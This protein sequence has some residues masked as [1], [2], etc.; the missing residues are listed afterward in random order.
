MEVQFVAGLIDE[1]KYVQSEPIETLVE[2]ARKGDADAFHRIYGLFVR[3]LFSFARR[4]LN[5][6]AEAEEV[7][8]ETFIMVFCKL[9][10]LKDVS[11]FEPWLFRVARNLVYMRYRK[12]SNEPSSFESDEDLQ[13]QLSQLATPGASPEEQAMEEERKKEAEKAIRFLPEKMRDVFL[14]SIFH[15]FSYQ[16]IAEI[17]GRSVAAVKSDLHRSRLLVREHLNE[18]F[19]CSL[20]NEDEM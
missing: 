2:L 4:M 1:R 10:S 17:T 3:R 19:H 5:S 14:L 7:V 6:H 12:R 18:Q 11:K 9:P 8:Q 16:K 15:G 13:E 20:K